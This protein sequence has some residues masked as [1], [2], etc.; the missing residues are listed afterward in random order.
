MKDHVSV[1]V[2]TFQRNKMLERLLRNMATQETG[3]LFD[4]S[5][6]VVDNDAAGPARQ[7]VCR[8]AAELCL[9]VSYGIEPD[10]S[11]AAARNHA[12]RLAH[13]NLV[14]IIDDDE[15]APD[16]WLAT[17]YRAMRTFDVDGCLGPVHPFFEHEPPRWLLKSKLCERPV[18]RTGTVL[19]WDETRTG[20][21]VLKREVFEK[22][23][24]QFNPA[25]RTGSSDKEFFKRAINA[26]CRFIAVSEA[27]VYEVVP[28]E[29]CRKSY[30][31]KRALVHGYTS[32]RNNLSEMH[33][34]SWMKL[35]LKSISVLLAYV[36]A[37]PFSLFLGSRAMMR[38]LVGGAH[39]F[40]RL[41][42]IL[43]V[44]LVKKRT[45]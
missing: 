43:G 9:D 20:N 15:L 2:A 42:A 45:F 34:L 6:V 5:V 23:H 30:Y 4:F 35:P 44:E 14:G 7:T 3:D 8:L 16:H 10:Q 28:P 41:C 24:L 37:L 1:C 26:G 12:L 18:H 17:M 29:R 32:Y 36:A 25:F 27:P 31:V 22:H 13:G 40:S 39:H 38:C 33:G 11:I 19:N 21:V